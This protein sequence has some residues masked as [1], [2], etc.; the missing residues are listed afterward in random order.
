LFVAKNG[1][2]LGPRGINHLVKRRPRRPASRP[3]SARIGTGMVTPA[4]R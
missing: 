4:T 1:R 2:R 3:S